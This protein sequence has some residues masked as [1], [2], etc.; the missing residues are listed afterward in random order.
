MPPDDGRACLED[1][2]NLG[3]IEVDVRAV[4]LWGFLALEA[5]FGELEIDGFGRLIFHVL[6]GSLGSACEVVV[7]DGVAYCEFLVYTAYGECQ[8]NFRKSSSVLGDML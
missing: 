1:T 2:G 4:G 8:A 3:G 6:A 7:S 5:Y